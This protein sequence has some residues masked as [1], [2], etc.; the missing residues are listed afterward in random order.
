MTH[1]TTREQLISAL[2][3]EYEMLT[4]DSYDPDDMSPAEFAEH[5]RSLSF[6]ELVEEAT[7][8]DIFTLEEFI[9][10]YS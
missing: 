7:V 1:T 2:I 8:D 5:V 3:C 10:N 6:D 4:H 9:L